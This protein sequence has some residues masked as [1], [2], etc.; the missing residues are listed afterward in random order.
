MYFYS[1]TIDVNTIFFSIQNISSA[2]LISG[3]RLVGRQYLSKETA[4][5]GSFSGTKFHKLKLVIDHKSSKSTKMYL[6][7]QFLGSFQ[8]H[9]VSRLKGGVFVLSKQNAVGLFRNFI[10]TPCN[11]FNAL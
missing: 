10:L 2:K 5:N 6:D 9:F 11:N 3:Y 7:N 8:E 4:V 1:N